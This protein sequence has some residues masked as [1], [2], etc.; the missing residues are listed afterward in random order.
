MWKYL[1]KTKILNLEKQSILSQRMEIKFHSM[2]G[3]TLGFFGRL[4]NSHRPGSLY[5]VKEKTGQSA[6]VIRDIMCKYR[7]LVWQGLSIKQSLCVPLKSQVK[8]M[9]IKQ[10]I[11]TRNCSVRLTKFTFYSQFTTN[12][13][14][15]LDSCHFC[16]NKQRIQVRCDSSNAR[17]KI[18][19]KI[20]LALIC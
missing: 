8:I 9:W 4:L 5:W 14:S 15:F 12:M 19:Q 17:R 16:R 2:S 13:Q 3:F 20:W 7:D 10:D 11:E 18:I 1:W 6:V